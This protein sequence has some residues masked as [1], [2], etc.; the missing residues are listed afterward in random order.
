M[1]CPVCR[2]DNDATQQICRQCKASL[3]AP[4]TTTPPT[5]RRRRPR[6]E[7]KSETPFSPYAEGLN[8]DAQWVYRLSLIG[9]VPFVGLLLGPLSA[10]LASRLRRKAKDDPGFTAHFLVR[11]AVAFGILTAL[12]QWAGLALMVLSFVFGV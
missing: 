2:T 11:A 8:R 6:S 9:L 5:R 4:A 10:V 7:D 1:Q 3:A 12:T